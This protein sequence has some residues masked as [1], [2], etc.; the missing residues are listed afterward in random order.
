MRGPADDA[1]FQ[2]R[3]LDTVWHE[4]RQHWTDA[5]ATHFDMRHRQIIDNKTIEY[6]EALRR[7]QELLSAAEQA[8]EH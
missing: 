3:A 2:R 6:V 5:G 7:L 4:T 8:T 1:E